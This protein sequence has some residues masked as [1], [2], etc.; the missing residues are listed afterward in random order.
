M[1]KWLKIVLVSVAVLG[2]AAVVARPLVFG[3]TGKS[4]AYG[5]SIEAKVVPD[6][7]TTDANRWV[8]GAPRTLASERGQVVLIEA[9]SP[10]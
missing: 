6:F 2:A 3:P 5:G 10:G 1:K 9:W 7:P 4:T 8:N